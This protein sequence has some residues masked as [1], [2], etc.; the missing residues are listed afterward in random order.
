M[1]TL[2]TDYG[3]EEVEISHPKFYV[4][5]DMQ[6]NLKD[7]NIIFTC[8]VSNETF[9]NKFVHERDCIYKFCKFNS[10]YFKNNQMEIR[11]F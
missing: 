1:T 7:M 9:K 2:L 6:P 3:F 10:K 5:K 4:K 11:P 8:P